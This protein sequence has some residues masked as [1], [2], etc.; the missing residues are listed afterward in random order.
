M[1]CSLQANATVFFAVRTRG[2]IYELGKVHL[3]ALQSDAELLTETFNEELQRSVRPKLRRAAPRR[4][5]AEEGAP[6]HEPLLVMEGGI[7]DSVRTDSSLGYPVY[8]A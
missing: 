1:A 7:H 3:L 5:D 4:D 2:N 6:D 8:E